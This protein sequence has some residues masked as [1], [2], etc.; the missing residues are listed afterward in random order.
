MIS[1][2]R[3]A[4]NFRG[5][6]AQENKKTSHQSA[7]YVHRSC[8]HSSHSNTNLQ[9]LKSTR[10]PIAWAKTSAQHDKIASAC[11]CRVTR[12]PQQRR[13]WYIH[14]Q[15]HVAAQHTPAGLS[16]ARQTASK[17]SE[18]GCAHKS[19]ASKAETQPACSA[20]SLPGAQLPPCSQPT[21][22]QPSCQRPGTRRGFTM[23]HVEVH[24]G[25]PWRAHLSKS[26]VVWSR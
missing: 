2:P 1:A 6:D 15:A 14:V 3:I 25:L 7:G 26:P 8:L 9:A 18:I 21:C 22:R 4:P 20:H 10:E 16:C 12:H 24:E 13:I 17:L 11:E 5:G 19:G 23:S